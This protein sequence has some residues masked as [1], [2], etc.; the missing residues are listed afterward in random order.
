MLT[1]LGMQKSE[2]L[3]TYSA[4]GFGGKTTSVKNIATGTKS[5]IQQRASVLTKDHTGSSMTA[6]SQ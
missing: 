6:H 5:S 4:L 3:T 2:T 1:Q